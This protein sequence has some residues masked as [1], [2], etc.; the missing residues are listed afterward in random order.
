VCSNAIDGE[1]NLAMAVIYTIFRSGE[2]THKA[3]ISIN[4]T[5]FH[6]EILSTVTS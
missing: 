1:L 5:R 2:Y 4:Y 6:T 3:I